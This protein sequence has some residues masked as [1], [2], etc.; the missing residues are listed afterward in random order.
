VQEKK[1]EVLQREKQ[2]TE[3]NGDMK[4]KLQI[5]TR[6]SAASVEWILVLAQNT[7]DLNTPVQ[8]YRRNR[9][10]I[11][12]GITIETNNVKIISIESHVTRRGPVDTVEEEALADNKANRIARSWNV[13]NQPKAELTASD[14]D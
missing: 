6:A 1:E 14:N 4:L 12:K 2:N 3:E 5:V 9:A 8:D 13:D 7:S 11:A 10:S